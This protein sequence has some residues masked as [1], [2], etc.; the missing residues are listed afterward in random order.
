MYTLLV[1]L[2]VLVCAFLVIVVLLQPGRG[3]MG[4][5]FGGG[6]SG[7]TPLLL[8]SLFPAQIRARSMGLAYQLAAVPAAFVPMG[9]AALN[10]RGIS[11]SGGIA[12]VVV[13]SELLVVALVLSAPRTDP[14]V[15]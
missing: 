12:A 13:L 8:S 6:H 7:V 5:A 15:T 11:W 1:V 9:I 14:T 10:A 3:G 4:G 2:Y